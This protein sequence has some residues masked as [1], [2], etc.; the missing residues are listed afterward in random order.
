MIISKN[1]LQKIVSQYEVHDNDAGE[2]FWGNVGAGVL[3]IC[4]TTKKILLAM[5]SAYVNEPNT[6]GVI[7]GKVDDEKSM[8]IEKE[9][10]RELKEESNYKGPI[11]LIPAYIFKAP[12]GSFT[13]Y[14]FIGLIPDEFD[15]KTDW[16]TKYFKWMTFDEMMKAKPKHFGLKTLLKDRKSLKLIKRYS[17]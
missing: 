11:K 17:E 12:S 10:K 1:K 6:W 7:G 15:L 4:I 2:N 9:V 5:R 14:N 8:N 13:Y 16:E 3:P